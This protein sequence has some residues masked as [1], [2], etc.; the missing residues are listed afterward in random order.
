MCP[1]HIR[2]GLFIVS[3]QT[4]FGL[5]SSLSDFAVRINAEG[6]IQQVS[7]SSQTFLQLPT[8]LLHES[9]ELFIQPEDMVLLIAAQ[10]AV[11]DSAERYTFTCRLLR[12]RVLPIWMD[13]HIL[14]MEEGDYLL[15]AFDATHWKDNEARLVH[16]STHDSLTGLPCK[17]LLDDRINACIRMAQR[18]K[19]SFTLIVLDLDSF[20][21]INDTLG[22]TGGDEIIK[23]V[24][25]RLQGCVRRSDTI[26]RIGGN[27]FSLIMMGVG[28][29]TV[30][31]I[32]KKILL[33]MQLTFYVGGHN[34]HI[35]TSLGATFY[36]VH[37]D[38]PSILYKYAEIAM[39]EAKAL[40]KGHWKIYE[41]MA[42]HEQNL[43]SLE[44]DMH[45]GIKNGEFILH[46]QP[47]FS[48]RTGKLKGAEALMRWNNQK[49]FIPP[50]TFIP[51]AENNGLIK[52]LG[53]WALRS[54]C[55]QAKIWQETGLDDFY[56]SVNVSPYQFVQEDF[57]RMMERVLAETGLSPASLMLE[58]TEGILM[59]SPKRT[60]TILTR[61][62]EAG[63]KIAI[64]DFGTG[65]SSLAYL[66]RFP[67][68]VLKIDKSFV[69][70]LPGSTEDTAIVT[71]ILSL[72]E[73]LGLTV[74]AEGVED[75]DQHEF[76][77]RRGCDLIQGYFTG[78]P[79]S[80]EDFQEKYII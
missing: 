9:I 71:T 75:L 34:V 25:E 78:R 17:I 47:I 16:L 80:I 46:Y 56:I 12:Q 5:L 76:L 30:E 22:Y 70:D 72:A 36:P 23:M 7:E 49:G 74:V 27:K 15:V 20:K 13:C 73:G 48:A 55:Y 37:G 4:P 40:G 28:Q 35:T 42:V 10:K 45:E 31:L 41:D 33:T 79:V 63:V 44:S 51:L 68:S 57:M 59:N 32:A 58:I 14:P 69:D 62:R 18:E 50:F 61:L 8:E 67:L 43:L 29:D 24:A 3:L 6:I 19:I 77:M 52:I 38:T 66:K 54:A 60:I 39:Y 26:A 11:I 65:Y 2:T 53:A 21:K 1:P 64:D